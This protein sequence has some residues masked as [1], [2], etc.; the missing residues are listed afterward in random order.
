MTI[1]VV[2]MVISGGVF[3]ITVLGDTFVNVMK[4]LPFMY[5]TYFPISVVTGALPL[6]E[7]LVSYGFQTLWIGMLGVL[8]RLVW[9]RG[10]RQYV[11]VGG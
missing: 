11:N 6:E 9:R 5:T 2:I 3:P 7:I 10:M 8:I 4:F 1:R